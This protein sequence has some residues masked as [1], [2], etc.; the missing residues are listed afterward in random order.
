[1]LSINM[2]DTSKEN[3]I[4]VNFLNI[5]KPKEATREI[6][7]IHRYFLKN[8][9]KLN[10]PKQLI[11]PF[12]LFNQKSQQVNP[13]NISL[14][15]PSALDEKIAAIG[16]TRNV[17]NPLQDF[18]KSLST[19][20]K[21]QASKLPITGSQFSGQIVGVIKENKEFTTIRVKRP[22]GWDFQ[23]GQYLEIRAEN[24]SI[25][26]PAT[27]AIA[28]GVGDDYIEFTGRPNP[29]SS[30]SHYCLNGN[31]GDYLTITGPLGA[32]F[33][34]HLVTEETPVLM[35]GGGSGLTA[36]KSLMDS[37]PFGT[38]IKLIYSSKTAQE[39][40]YHEDI[41]KWKAQGHTISLTQDRVDGFQ[42]GRITEH[43]AKMKI[44]PNSLIFLCGP[45]ELVLGT[46][47]MLAEMGVPREMIFGSL[48]VRAN[49]GGPVFRGDHPKMMA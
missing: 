8:I 20:T 31:V 9:N 47:K 36:L 19:I 41:E 16:Q 43:L 44:K 14:D 17:E 29:N 45:K 3:K 23:P 48:P 32:N 28:S 12:S 34:I 5:L 13:L 6:L 33:P 25:N 38:D 26:R 15:S 46:A 42:N 1:M 39:L 11:S 21:P 18:I 37:L 7:A 10:K 49:E 4:S 22:A 2:L 35:L 40:L 30:H 27:L 24:S